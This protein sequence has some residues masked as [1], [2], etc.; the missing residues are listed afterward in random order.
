MCDVFSIVWQHD[1]R[2]LC[3]E[4]CANRFLHNMVRI[5]VGTM[6]EV[7]RGKLTP[8]DVAEILQRGDRKRAGSA[9]PP[10]GLFLVQVNY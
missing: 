6:I 10:Q 2:R 5:I 4:I 7:G 3:M 1:E 8:D 9:A